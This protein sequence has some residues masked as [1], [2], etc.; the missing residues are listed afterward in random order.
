MS[1]LSFRVERMILSQISFEVHLGNPLGLI[2]PNGGGKTSLIQILSG[3]RKPTHGT[4][5]RYSVKNR[6]GY[7]AQFTERHTQ[8]PLSTLEFVAMGHPDQASMGWA[9]SHCQ[10]QAAR[11]ALAA[12]HLLQQEKE[13]VYD[14]SGGQLQRAALARAIVHKPDILL[15]DEP[16]ANTDTASKRA[17]FDL[18]KKMRETIVMIVA[19]HD[20]ELLQEICTDYLCLQCR[21]CKMQKKDLSSHFFLMG[22]HA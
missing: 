8:I 15:L 7:V 18:L 14:L 12:V 9:L 4:I 13:R 6:I 5:E 1:N 11:E 19:S 22:K 21:G 2:G 17:V 3:L 16:T 10:I 20:L